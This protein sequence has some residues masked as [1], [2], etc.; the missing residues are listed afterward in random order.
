MARATS[1]RFRSPCESA[2]AGSSAWSAIPTNSR[3][4]IA[5]ASIFRT[6]SP[7]ACALGASRG[8]ITL[9]TMG[10]WRNGLVFWKVQAM[11]RFTTSHTRSELMSSPLKI[12]F[13]LSA[14]RTRVMSLRR[15]VL[16]APFGPISPTIWSRRSSKPTSLTASS[17]PKR[18]VRRSTRKNG[19]AIQAA[20]PSSRSSRRETF[21]TSVR[22][23]SPRN[24][25]V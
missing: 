23:S 20:G 14:R 1:S 7:R 5:F 13:P 19:S 21:P 25:I 3:A 4:S 18:R 11:P 8:T 16:P 6:Q 17:P 24:S 2:E 22:G 15:V 10:R 9:A 12:T